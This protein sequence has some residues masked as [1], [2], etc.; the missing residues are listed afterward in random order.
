MYVKISVTLPC[1]LLVHK[2]KI[3]P[4]LAHKYSVLINAFNT[5]DLDQY[6]NNI[7]LI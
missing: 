1:A 6:L 3:V 2:E 4:K 5:S 7:G